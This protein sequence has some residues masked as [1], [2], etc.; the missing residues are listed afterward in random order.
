MSRSLEAKEVL[1][2]VIS[3]L[4]NNLVMNASNLTDE[5]KKKV[6]EE[7]NTYKKYKMDVCFILHN[8]YRHRDNFVLALDYCKEHSQ[9]N[10][11][12]HKAESQYYAYALLLEALCMSKI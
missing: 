3:Q 6:I 11:E 1:D 8:L 9:L 4:D 7:M 10:R 5:E 2:S 12:I